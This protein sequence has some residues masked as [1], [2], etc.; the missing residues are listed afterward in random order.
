[1]LGTS[2]PSM[3]NSLKTA[4]ILLNNLLGGSCFNSQLNLLLREEHGLT[5][6]IE[7]NY[8]AYTDTGIFSI[9]FGTDVSK[10]EQ[11]KNLLFEKFKK[12][13]AVGV[14]SSL[15]EMYKKQL[16]GQFALSF[17]N[18]VAYMISNAKSYMNYKNVDTYNESVKKFKI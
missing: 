4:M 7:S 9:Y 10:I 18:H 12:I 13:R 15:L 11:C 2:A 8:T 1:M 14:R 3:H 17:D 16:I 6:N 5:Y